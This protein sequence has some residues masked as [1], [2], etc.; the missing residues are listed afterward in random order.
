MPAA[1]RPPAKGAARTLTVARF[2]Q[3]MIL[4]EQLVDENTDLF[5]GKMHSFREKHREGTD[6]K[7]NAEEAAQ[8]AA[9]LSAAIEE[10]SRD[11]VQLAEQVQASGL[12]AYDQPSSQEVLMAAGVATAPAFIGAALRLVALLEIPEGDFEQAY[13]DGSLDELVGE[14]AGELRKLDLEDA[15]KLTAEKLDLLASKSGA[16]SGEGLRSLVTAVWRALTIAAVATTPSEGSGLS[17]LTG[18]LEA[19]GGADE[20]SSTPSL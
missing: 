7:L 18:S 14:K 13:D 2:E 10:E 4:L 6:R 17:S 12:R 16:G 20:T 15:R 19:M 1:K 3:A 9:A 8:V 5:I 11:A